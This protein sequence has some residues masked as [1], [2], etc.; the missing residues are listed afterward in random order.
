QNAHEKENHTPLHLAGKYHAW[1]SAWWL[2]KQGA[3]LSIKDAYGFTPLGRLISNL[4]S[5]FGTNQSHLTHTEEQSQQ[6]IKVFDAV[7]ER[8]EAIDLIY[9]A[10][11]SIW[12]RSSTLLGYALEHGCDPN[13]IP[14]FLN[15]P[16]LHETAKQGWFAG[17][18][19]LVGAGA[20]PLRLGELG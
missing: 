1:Q 10:R 5:N 16:L 12:V 3:D 4:S 6:I 15:H 7:T 2:V 11:Q 13:A 9:L 20:S 18:D 14:R 19:V 8:G 17:Y